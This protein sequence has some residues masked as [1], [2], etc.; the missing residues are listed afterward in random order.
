MLIYGLFL[1]ITN[2]NFKFDQDFEKI[3]LNILENFKT[4]E[5]N[6]YSVLYYL[7]NKFI[8]QTFENSNI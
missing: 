5:I 4:F 3:Q 1:K 7:I 6:P 8:Y 2:K